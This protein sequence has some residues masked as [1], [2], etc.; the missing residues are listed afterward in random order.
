MIPPEDGDDE[1]MKN[2]RED[3]IGVIPQTLQEKMMK[4]T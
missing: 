1:K 3:Y 4:T 2:W